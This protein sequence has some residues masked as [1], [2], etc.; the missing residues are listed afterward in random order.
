[1]LSANWQP[2]CLGFNVLKYRIFILFQPME[3]LYKPLI[4]FQEELVPRGIPMKTIYS[5][6][7][8]HE[9]ERLSESRDR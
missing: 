6:Y 4:E 2:F 1:M 9:K 3:I 7:E 5:I 8:E